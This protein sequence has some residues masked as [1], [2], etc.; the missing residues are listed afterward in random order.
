MLTQETV[1]WAKAS[2]SCWHTKMDNY[3]TRSDFTKSEEDV[4]LDHIVVE[5]KFL[6]FFICQWFDFDK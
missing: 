4:N 1:V 3:F 2:T 6:V 5:G